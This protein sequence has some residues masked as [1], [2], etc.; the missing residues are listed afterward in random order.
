MAVSG[1]G[2]NWSRL[3]RANT[4]SGVAEIWKAIAP[5]ALRGA[6]VTSTGRKAGYHQSLTVVA[7]VGKTGTG[8]VA[9]GGDSS[10]APSLT[11]TT[12]NPNA[13]VVS[14]G[15]D[16]DNAASKTPGSGQ[17]L[18][19]QWADTTTLDTYWV[20]ATAPAAAPCSRRVSDSPCSIEG[21]CMVFPFARPVSERGRGH[22]DGFRYSLN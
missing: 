18:L 3:A 19:H 15:N 13:Y 11:V 7:Y 8:A 10:G 4:Q 6:T 17:V 9:V 20:Q 1:G 21:T 12:T 22:P 2:L 14:V 5:T 16:W